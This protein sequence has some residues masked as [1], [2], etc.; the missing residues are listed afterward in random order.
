MLAVKLPF[1]AAV[2]IASPRQEKRC[3]CFFLAV[4]TKTSE[5]ILDPTLRF[6]QRFIFP[7]L[8]SRDLRLTVWRNPQHPALPVSCLFKWQGLVNARKFH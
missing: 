2:L 4:E 8:S 6:Q 3:C 5:Q 1:P 7:L